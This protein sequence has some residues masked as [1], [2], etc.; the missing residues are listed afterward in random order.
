VL[1]GRFWHPNHGFTYFLQIDRS[2]ASSMVPALQG[3][4]VYIHAA[5]GSYD[6]GYYAQ[7]ATDPGLGDP[8]LPKAI[9]DPGYRARRILLGAVAWCLGGGEAVRVVHAYAWLNIVLWFG[10]AALLWRVFPVGEWRATLAWAFV[11]GG[12][13]VLFSVRFALTDLAALLL[14]AGG[15]L[16]I[17]RKRSGVAAGLF[18]LAGLA[19]ETGVLGACALLP[20]SRAQLASPWKWAG[21]LALVG[22]PLVL[23]LA[24]V[25]QTLGGSSAGQGNLSWLPLTGWLG[26]WKELA[27]GVEPADSWIWWESLLEHVA[28]SVQ[29][30]Y[31]LSRPKKNCP[32]WRAGMA[33][34]VL[35]ICLGHAVWGGFPNAASRVLL[36][37]TLVFNVLAVRN[38]AALAWLL[39][40]NLS[41]LAG[42]H[43]LWPAPRT[44]E[45][46]AH[47]SWTSFQMLETDERWSTTERNWKWHWAW[48]AQEGSLAFSTWPQAEQVQLHL[49]MRGVTPR[50][51]TVS[52]R[53]QVV[54]QG[55]I[56][57][58]PQW[59][60]LPALPTQ[61]GRLVL[62]LRSDSPPVKE[63]D[64]PY[65]RDLGFACFGVRR[66]GD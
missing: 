60:T 25:H 8:A 36:P 26:R 44:H 1:V 38:R 53:G 24:Y 29:A 63:G 43:A 59:I 62:E 65:P 19:R 28:L 42:V 17:E 7:I 37:L 31:L 34:V 61:G 51:L 14:T 47:G 56:G 66:V 2:M 22:L 27:N 11:L 54:W 52:H 55:N 13:G 21:W 18:G 3:K 57:D 58:R 49:Q 39:A 41:I 33:Y 9:D 32:W 30:V 20:G 64:G 45:L 10:L 48:C 46:P 40:G 23:W 4:P 6:G 35:L 50:D 15:I 16:L 5:P 12:A